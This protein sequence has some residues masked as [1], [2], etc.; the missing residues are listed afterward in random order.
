MKVPVKVEK[1]TDFRPGSAKPKLIEKQIWL[2][3]IEMPKYLINDVRQGSYELED[4]DIDLDD[5]DQSYID[6]LDKA[7]EEEQDAE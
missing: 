5:L 2:V 6:D 7:H 3:E 4:Q 1:Y